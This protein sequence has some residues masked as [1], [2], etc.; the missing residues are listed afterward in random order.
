LARWY[1]LRTLGVQHRTGAALALRKMQALCRDL[2]AESR[3]FDQCREPGRLI[4]RDKTLVKRPDVRGWCRSRCSGARQRRAAGGMLA[5]GRGAGEADT[6]RK[7]RAIG[8]SSASR[9][10]SAARSRARSTT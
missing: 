1:L 5:A 10:R 8:R 2:G 7:R 4:K 9:V 3:A 6:S